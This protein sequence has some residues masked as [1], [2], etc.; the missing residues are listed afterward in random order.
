MCRL[1]PMA[2]LGWTAKARSETGFAHRLQEL[3]SV[4]RAGFLRA[5]P[6]WGEVFSREI[7][8]NR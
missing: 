8:G 7:M 2:T 4:G 3:A 6:Y 1:A 5:Y